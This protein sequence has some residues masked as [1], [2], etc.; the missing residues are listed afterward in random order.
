MI[1]TIHIMELEKVPRERVRIGVGEKLP[2]Q[3]EM[4]QEEGG[5]EKENKDGLTSAKPREDSLKW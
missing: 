5:R 3:G 1:K 2:F 4:K